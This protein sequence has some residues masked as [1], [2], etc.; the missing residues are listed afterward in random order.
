[1]SPFCMEGDK[2]GRKKRPWS[3]EDYTYKSLVND[4]MLN[5]ELLVE[6]MHPKGSR[7]SKEIY[8]NRNSRKG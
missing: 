5:R 6:M 7:T 1:M 2:S 4:N 3:F 8:Q